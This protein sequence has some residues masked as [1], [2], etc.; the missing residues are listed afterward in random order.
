MPKKPAQ[1]SN[2]WD[3]VF[4]LTLKER[5]RIVYAL[6]HFSEKSRA[7]PPSYTDPPEVLGMRDRKEVIAALRRVSKAHDAIARKLERKP[8]RQSRAPAQNRPN[9][10]KV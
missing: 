10:S 3:V 7:N 1:R 8:R 9:A 2:F 4:R 5:Q 6:R